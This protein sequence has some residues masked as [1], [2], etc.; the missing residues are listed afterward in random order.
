MVLLLVIPMHICLLTS[1]NKRKKIMDTIREVQASLSTMATSYN[2]V[3]GKLAE[4]YEKIYEE[5]YG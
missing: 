3:H 5:V 1:N 4:T 2:E